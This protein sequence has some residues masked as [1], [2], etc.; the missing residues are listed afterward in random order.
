MTLETAEHLFQRLASASLG[1]PGALAG[2]P[3]AR[4]LLILREFMR[5]LGYR[6]IEGS[7]QTRC[8][9][10]R[11]GAMIVSTYSRR[12]LVTIPSADAFTQESPCGPSPA[13][14]PLHQRHRA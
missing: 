14:A 12:W 7:S 3:V 13:Q 6:V 8:A 2:L 11:A 4:R 1:H 10:R 9:A 5:H